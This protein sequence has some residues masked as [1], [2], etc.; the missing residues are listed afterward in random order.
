MLHLTAIGTGLYIITVLGTGGSDGTRI[1]P[2][3]S[4]TRLRAIRKCKLTELHGV[5][6]IYT[7]DIQLKI[8]IRCFCFGNGKRRVSQI[9]FAQPTVSYRING[10]P[11]S[12]ALVRFVIIVAGRQ[13]PFC[14]VSSRIFSGVIPRPYSISTDVDRLGCFE[15]HIGRID[16]FTAPFRGCCSVK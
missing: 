15:N 9:F 10:L 6:I 13:R 14:R 1:G 2:I 5:S 11:C 7:C 16:K 8:P 12:A 4:C 3:V